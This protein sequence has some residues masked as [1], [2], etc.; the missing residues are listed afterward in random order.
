MGSRFIDLP[1]RVLASIIAIG[2]VISGSTEDSEPLYLVMFYLS[3]LLLVGASFFPVSVAGLLT[4]LFL[5][6]LF[7][8]PQHLNPFQES[9][10]FCVA[11]LIATGRWRTAFAL[12]ATMFGLI[13][14]TQH[15]QPHIA[16]SFSELGF[17][18]SL[19]TALA[20][21]AFLLERHIRKE[22]RRRESAAVAHEQ[23]LQRLRLQ[24]ALDAHDTIS[25][26]LATQAAV[27]RVL[28]YEETDPKLRSKLSELA[29][30]NDLTHQDLRSF[31][32]KLRTTHTAAPV[33]PSPSSEF[34]QHFDS[35]VAAAN[36][37]GY[38]IEA[39][40]EQVP[41]AFSAELAENLLFICRELVTNIVKHSSAQQGCSVT[42]RTRTDSQKNMLVV[43]SSNPSDAEYAPAP[44]SLANRVSSLGGTCHTQLKEQQ[45]TVTVTLPITSAGEQA[46]LR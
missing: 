36:A 46:T 28:S 40:L 7:A 8:Y 3:S 12:V 23:Q 15:I 20:V 22:I 43:E 42:V 31:L 16:T 30:L 19:A 38:D 9:L 6:H 29:I 32:Y 34:H 17:S 2:S 4:A 5:I 35:L 33:D 37:G 14:L 13:W 25:H 26:G 10:E 44:E 27:I 24:V 11:V 45:F 39:H 1:V 18:L 21:S 41:A